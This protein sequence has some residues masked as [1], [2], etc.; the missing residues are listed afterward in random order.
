M[1]R[2]LMLI[3]HHFTATIKRCKTNYGF[4][5]AGGYCFPTFLLKTDCCCCHQ[6]FVLYLCSLAAITTYATLMICSAI[7][8]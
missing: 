2:L 7:H 1:K 5:M 4:A 8:I 3:L 6:Q